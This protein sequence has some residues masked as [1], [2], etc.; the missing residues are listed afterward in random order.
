VSSGSSPVLGLDI[1]GS[2]SRARLSEGGRVLAEAE[3]MGANVAEV[4]P[5]TVERRLAAL[6]ADLGPMH[7]AACCAG[8]AGAEVP[9]ARKRLEKLLMRL[10]PDCRITVVH[11]T[12]LILAA[13]GL[14]SGIALIA[15]TGSVAYGRA[16]DGREIRIGGWGWLLGDEGS[17]VWL[18]REAAREVM[19][20]ADAGEPAGR[21]GETLI[22][23]AR[24]RDASE[25]TGRLHRFREPRS[26]AELAHVVFE[27]ADDDPG[28]GALIELAADALTAL[29][30]R[31][32]ERLSYEGPVV[33]AG[34][35]LLHQA[36]LESAVRLRLGSIV[37]RLAEPPVAG[38]VT[39]AELNVA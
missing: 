37:V 15:G 5:R 7:P 8:S 17:A 18:A 19:R 11:D 1:G 6:L 4:P 39:L 30:K 12:R 22:E 21:L 14:E 27:T 2:S 9:A 28:A 38:A 36:R 13:A 32:Q 31:V 10:L 34:G 26:W 24:A 20:R 29:V 16:G 35:L 23:A 25:L 33:L 3:G